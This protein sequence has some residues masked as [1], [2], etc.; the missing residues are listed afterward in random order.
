MAKTFSNQVL[1]TNE[2]APPFKL[3]GVDGK[4]YSLEDFNCKCVLV[5]FI[6]NHCPYVKACIND[7][8]NLQNSFATSELKLV[9]I[10]SNDSDYQD[11]GFDKMVKFAEKY[12]L[13]FPYL[14][15]DTQSVARAYGATCTPDPF[16]FDQHK[17]LVFHGRINDATD[18]EAIPKIP[19]MKNNVKRVLAGKTL[20]K[21]FDPSIGCS[22]KWKA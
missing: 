12:E 14:T 21:D 20:E 4:M 17:R 9:G 15:D 13:N 7:L 5:V 11:E 3:K 10:N 16:L 19:I 18:P 2:K 22:I 6:C 1:K 8:I